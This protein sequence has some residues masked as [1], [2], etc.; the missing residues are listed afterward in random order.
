MFARERD[1][2]V[3]VGCVRPDR[4]T[5]LDTSGSGTVKNRVA[6]SVEVRVVEV[7]VGVDEHGRKTGN[8]WNLES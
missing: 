3:A 1:G 2:P 6:I 7:G 5:N 8:G 4:H